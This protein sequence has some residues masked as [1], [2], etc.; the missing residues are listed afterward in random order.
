MS[1]SSSYETVDP[2][3]VNIF[4]CLNIVSTINI[5]LLLVIGPLYAVT[6][7][8]CQDIY[9]PNS[10]IGLLIMFSVNHLNLMKVH[11]H[12]QTKVY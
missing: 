3:Y 11:G 9:I 8:F 12:L 1:F 10:F 4:I 7:G 6:L 2:K 5:L